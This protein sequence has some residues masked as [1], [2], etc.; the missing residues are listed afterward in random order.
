LIACFKRLSAET[1]RQIGVLY[2]SRAT[3]KMPVVEKAN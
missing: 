2:V 1:L 3:L